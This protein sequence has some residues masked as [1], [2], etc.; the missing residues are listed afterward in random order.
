MQAEAA[1]IVEAIQ[2]MEI[3]ELAAEVAQ[4]DQA[5]Q[6]LQTQAVAA[7]EMVLMVVQES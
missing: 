3:T 7:E 2:H 1:D 6:E 4:V 5:Q